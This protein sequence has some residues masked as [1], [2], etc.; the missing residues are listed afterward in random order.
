MKFIALIAIA[1]S[2]AVALTRNAKN[3]CGNAA[4]HFSSATLNC[5]EDQICCETTKHTPN[6][7][8]VSCTAKCPTDF[9]K[10]ADATKHGSKCKRRRF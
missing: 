7:Q 3:H 6:G 10:A 4:T 5:K 8:C 1:S 9:T 2:I